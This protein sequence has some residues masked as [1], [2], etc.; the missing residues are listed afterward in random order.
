MRNF[1]KLFYN[2]LSYRGMYAIHGGD[3]V[4]SFFVYI[5]EE[6]K[7]NSYAILIMPNPM[8][9]QY[10]SRCEIKSDL[11]FDNIRFVE[12][13]PRPVYDVCKAN[14]LYYAKKAGIHE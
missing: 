1:L 13:M 12:K 14:F 7:G 10:V 2:K 4:G 3:K 5:K 9:A 8:E 11:K 6:D